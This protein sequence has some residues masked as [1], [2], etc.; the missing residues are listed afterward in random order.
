MDT[1]MVVCDFQTFRQ[2]YLPFDPCKGEVNSALQVLQEEKLLNMENN[3]CQWIS[4]GHPRDCK[5]IEDVAFEPLDDI[6]QTL[7]DRLPAGNRDCNFSYQKHP[8]A[9]LASDI[10]GSNHRIDGSFSCKG[11]NKRTVETHHIAVIAEFKKKCNDINVQDVSKN[12]GSL[13]FLQLNC[14]QNRLK[15]LGAAN[16]VMNDDVQRIHTFGVS[17]AFRNHSLFVSEDH[18]RLLR[19]HQCP[20]GT[21]LARTLPNPSPL[22]SLRYAILICIITNSILKGF[23]GL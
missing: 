16:H 13:M 11:T 21:S 15:M 20:S 23:K 19:T 10:A 8:N 4:F 22:I 6:S 7:Q 14:L 3:K 9:K 2:H 1:E 12:I 17:L 18:H 5:D